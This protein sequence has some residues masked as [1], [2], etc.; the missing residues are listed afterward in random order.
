LHGIDLTVLPE[1]LDGRNW[2]DGKSIKNFHRNQYLF[3]VDFVERD[4]MPFPI[5]GG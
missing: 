2:P 4:G 3:P 5:I 1:G